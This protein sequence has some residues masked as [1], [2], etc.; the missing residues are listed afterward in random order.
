MIL[1]QQ[2]SSLCLAASSF[3]NKLMKTIFGKED[4]ITKVILWLKIYQKCY[5]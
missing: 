3:R 5:L 1:I 2:T 4:A